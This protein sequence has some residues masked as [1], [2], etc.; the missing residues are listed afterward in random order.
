MGD[1][2]V[3]QD[4]RLIRDTPSGQDRTLAAVVPTS[5][6]C[7]R[8][9]RGECLGETPESVGWRKTVVHCADPRVSMRSGTPAHRSRTSGHESATR[10]HSDRVSV[11]VSFVVVRGGS[12]TLA[13]GRVEHVADADD[14]A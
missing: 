2:A 10:R 12:V 6:L 14:R 5:G 3:R 9:V 4:E 13:D 8:P 11:F 7:M 1:L